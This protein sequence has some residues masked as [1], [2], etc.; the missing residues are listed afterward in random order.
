[1]GHAGFARRGRDIVCASVST[2][3]INTINSMEQLADEKMEVTA[4]EETGFIHCQ[5]PAPLSR[6]GKLFM[7]SM[8]LGLSGI[9]REYGRKGRKQYLILNFEEV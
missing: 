9:A 8:V 1:M 2:L 6:E 7:D 5:F 4:N 3:V